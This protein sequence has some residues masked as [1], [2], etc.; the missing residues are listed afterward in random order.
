M[1]IFKEYTDFDAV[2]I[3]ELIKSKKIQ[4]IDALDTAIDLIEQLDPKLNF[5]HQKTYHFAMESL[6]RNKDLNGPFAGVPMLMKDMDS[7][8]YSVPMMQ[9]SNYL[10]DIP[11]KF[12]NS[13]SKKFTNSG[14]LI[15]GKSATPEFGLMITTEPKAFKP[16][17]NPWDRERS[18]GGSSG[19]AGSAVASRAVPIA[20]A[21]DGGG[22][23]RIPAAT[24]GTVGLKP[25]RGRISF[26]PSH[27]DK[28]GG[29]THSGILSR[30]VRDTAYMYNELFSSE[31]GDPYSVHYEKGSLI[32]SLNANKKYKIGFNTESR[33]P[34][35][36]TSDAKNA[37][38]H[39]AKLCESIGHNVEECNIDYDG[40][41]LSRAFA[42][43]ISSHV[44]QMFNE[45]KD[46]VGRSFKKSEVETAS[47]ALNYLG[48]SFRGKDYAWA[49][50][51]IQ[52]ISRDVM[53]QTNDYDAVILPIISQSAPLLGE[54]R[55]KKNNNIQNEILMALRLGFLFRIP[56]IRDPFLNKNIIENYWYSP[57]AVLQNVTGQ[58]S[59]SLPTFYTNNNLPL[60]VQFAGRYAEESVLIDLASQLEQANP[61]I[62]K[63][64]S[65][66]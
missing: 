40:L 35:T 51:T 20:H 13:L 15:C 3:A 21:S 19:G 62:D 10:K 66:S 22:S 27:G 47:R 12:N 26:S 59:I 46:L 9:G 11:M 5:M 1:P 30:T 8:L 52:K 28:W 7:A 42:I 55:P 24:C 63:K 23:I 58:P 54:L 14:T 49:R 57:D 61:W 60:G 37:V 4:A 33:L 50:Y 39:N 41:L 44:S 64:P 31:I 34:I 32:N 36:I 56:F 17:R 43:I 6:N 48:K 16:T 2:G 25:T 53:Q 18:T 29:L 45:L 65:I 38:M